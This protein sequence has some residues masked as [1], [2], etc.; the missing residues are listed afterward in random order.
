VGR[1]LATG[2]QEAVFSVEVSES[3][4]RWLSPDKELGKRVQLALCLAVGESGPSIG[5]PRMPGQRLA[6]GPKMK[7]PDLVS[8]E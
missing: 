1:T 8:R 6:S 2:F 5:E 3:D 4:S 7:N